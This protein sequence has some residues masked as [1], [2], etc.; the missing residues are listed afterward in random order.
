MSIP[1]MMAWHKPTWPNVD[2]S[3]FAVLHSVLGDGRSSILYKE[4]VQ[5]KR[6]ATSIFTTEAPGQRF[7]QLFVVGGKPAPGVTNERLAE[8]VQKILERI[9]KEGVDE[10]RIA[11]AKRRVRKEYLSSLSSNY[12]MARALGHAELIWGD[13]RAVATSYDEILKT[14][15]DDISRL[16]SSYLIRENRTLAFLET[17]KNKTSDDSIKK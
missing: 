13:W 8:E 6:I 5:E 15:S 9:A 11:A 17:A 7:P 12:G 2:D 4:L 1:R 16:V 10:S 3:K 14:T